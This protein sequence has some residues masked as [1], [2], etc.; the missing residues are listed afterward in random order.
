MHI[1]IF[2]KTLSQQCRPPYL[3]SLNYKYESRTNNG[4]SKQNAHSVKG[5]FRKALHIVINAFLL[6]FF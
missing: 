4:L 6:I 2:F 3:Y 5:V 1:H